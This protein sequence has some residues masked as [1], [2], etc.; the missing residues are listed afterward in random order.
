MVDLWNIPDGTCMTDVITARVAHALRYGFTIGYHN[1]AQRELAR[2]NIAQAAGINKDTL[3]TYISPVLDDRYRIVSGPT[4]LSV[5]HS[6]ILQ[7]G[8]RPSQLYDAAEN[9]ETLNEFLH[10][11]GVIFLIKPQSTFPPMGRTARTD[12]DVHRLS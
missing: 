8:V 10:R 11:I 7:M 4:K 5:F 1:G 3:Q 6:I 12:T 9:S 2:K